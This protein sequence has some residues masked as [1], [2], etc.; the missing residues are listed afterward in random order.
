MGGRVYTDVVTIGNVSIY[1]VV[2]DPNG[3]LSAP[4]GS[5]AIQDTAGDPTTWQ[6]TNGGTAW[7]I[8]YERNTRRSV[9]PA[10]SL[11][12]LLMVPP[13]S[14]LVVAFPVPE[15]CTLKQLLMSST[16]TGVASAFGADGVTGYFDNTLFL[17]IDFISVDVGPDSGA[18]LI[19]GHSPCRIFS[20]QNPD[21]APDMNIRCPAGSTVSVRFNNLD[22][23]WAVPIHP[24]WSFTPGFSAAQP[25]NTLIGTAVSVTALPVGAGPAAGTVTIV[26]APLA[27]GD[28]IE[29][30]TLQDNLT[31]TGVAGARTP[32]LNDFNA[33]LVTVGLLQAEIVSA[34]NDGLNGFAADYT[35]AVSGPADVVVTMNASGK[36]GNAQNIIPTTAP[37]GG[38]TAAAPTFTGGTSLVTAVA[39]VSPTST[40]RLHRLFIVTAIGEGSDVNQFLSVPELRIAAAPVAA[41]S[42]EVNGFFFDPKWPGDSISIDV[43][44][45]AAAGIAVDMENAFLA[46]IPVLTSFFAR[47]AT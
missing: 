20:S 47:P 40:Y 14:S 32:G 35:A 16:S 39:Y 23:T 28:T 21:V 42:G 33:T 11:G 41:F 43:L 29:I 15:A 3:V 13:S 9:G 8:V 36:L 19:F 7:S 2:V 26:S 22:S 4:L 5:L 24:A 17:T 46:G 45:A 27:A 44:V 37:V 31:L 18:N 38:I 6:N 12:T 1:N 25:P 30:G 10:L 34:I